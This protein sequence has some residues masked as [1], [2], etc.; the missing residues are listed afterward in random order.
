MNKFV[1]EARDPYIKTVAIWTPVKAFN[2]EVD[3]S[4]RCHDEICE[5][6]DIWGDDLDA[7]APFFRV[8]EVK[9]AI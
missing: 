4:E 3:A 6:A 7:V 2:N 9:C 1:V 8:R 5:S